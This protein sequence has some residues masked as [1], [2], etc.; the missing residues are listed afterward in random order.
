MGEFG[1]R[2]SARHALLGLLV[3]RPGYPYQLADRLHTRLGSGWKINSGQLYQT[4]DKL[5]EER[6]IER[7]GEA[8]EEAVR[9]RRHIYAITDAGMTEFTEWLARP[10]GPGR[11]QRWTLILKIA[12]GGPEQAEDT[13]RVID[14]REGDC[15]ARMTQISS[16]RDKE[17][18]AHWAL[19]EQTVYRLS[20]NADLAQVE[21]ELRFVREARAEVLLLARAAA[22]PDQ[23]KALRDS[24]FAR[25]DVFDRIASERLQSTLGEEQ[26][27][28]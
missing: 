26:D 2:M 21:A 8:T 22:S 25:S 15:V 18:P 6:L 7:V 16:E 3:D 24:R 19:A 14:A 4:I 12:F 23:E 20:L 13:L 11:L 27:G 9:G 10:L 5:E 17:L 1:G 28:D